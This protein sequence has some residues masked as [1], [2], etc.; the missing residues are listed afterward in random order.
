MIWVTRSEPGAGKVAAALRDAGYDAWCEPL[1][2]I[3][4]LHPVEVQVTGTAADVSRRQPQLVI[5]LSA[6][7]AEGYVGSAWQARAVGVTHV[8]IGPETARLLQQTGLDVVIPEQASSEGVMAMTQVNAVSREHV[9]W[10]CAGQGG[11]DVLQKYFVEQLGCGLVRL[12]F[13]RRVQRSVSNIPVPGINA[14]A[15]GSGAGLEAFANCWHAAGGDPSVLLLVPS[16]RVASAAR[17]M[18]FENVHNAGGAGPREV[19]AG[20][21]GLMAQ[22]SRIQGTDE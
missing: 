16:A 11:R 21:A 6:H 3:E 8:A 17:A 14:V 18:G 7:A 19:V 12:N 1:I 2:G 15:L 4:Q 22:D 5:V 13:Y 10:L 20:L 9:V